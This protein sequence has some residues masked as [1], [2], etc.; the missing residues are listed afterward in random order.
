[1]HYCNIECVRAT[2]SLPTPCPAPCPTPSIQQF[3]KVLL[4]YH[5][6]FFFRDKLDG[7]L[8]GMFLMDVKDHRSRGR[9]YKV[10]KVNLHATSPLLLQE[11]SM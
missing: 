2:L 7:T 10:I 11:L 5:Y 6:V 1:M 4:G 9:S 8:R 3:W